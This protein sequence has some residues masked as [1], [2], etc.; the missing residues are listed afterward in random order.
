MTSHFFPVPVIKRNLDAMEAVKL[1]VFHWHL[2]DDQGFRVES[3][4]FPKLHSLGSG[5][6]LLH[7]ARTSATL[8]NMP[9]T[10]ASA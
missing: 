3:Q 9:V 1:N 6:Q 10:A 4:V 2:T 5:G 8:S 7:A